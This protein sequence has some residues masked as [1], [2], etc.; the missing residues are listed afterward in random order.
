MIL[1]A[2]IILPS[3]VFTEKNALYMNIFGKL[4]ETKRIYFPPKEARVD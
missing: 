4:K 2:D 1:D 3:A